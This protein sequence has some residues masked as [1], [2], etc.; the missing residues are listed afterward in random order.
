M[1]IIERQSIKGSLVNYL[2]VFIGFFATLF[3]Y[4]LDWELYGTIQYWI[5][6]AVILTPIL[7][8]GSTALLNKFYPHFKKKEIS[9][10]LGL[11]LIISTLTIM[12]M[13][14]L[15][16]LFIFIFRDFSFIQQMNIQSQSVVY[17]YL[18]AVVMIYFSIF[19]LHAANVRRIV[20][21]EIISKVGFKL[22]LIL[23]IVSSYFGILDNQWVG[24]LLVLFYLLACL[25]MYFYLII[26]GGLDLSGWKWKK[27]PRNLKKKMVSFWVF[28]GLNYLGVLLAYKIDLFMIG[29]LVDKVSVGYYSIFLF[30]VN[31]MIIPMTSINQIAGPIVSESFEN[32]DL[33]KIEQIYKKSSNTIFSFGTLVIIIIW[34]NIFFLLGIMR[35]GEDLIPYVSVILFLGLAKVFDLLTSIN[36][37]III[38]SRWYQLNLVFLAIMSVI[39]ILL[40]LYF[41][42]VYGII[43]A[44]YATSISLFVFNGIKSLFIYIKFGIH[45]FSK[46]TIYIV[47]MLAAGILIASTIQDYPIINDILSMIIYSSLTAI[48]YTY[49]NY[50]LGTSPELNQWVDKRIFRK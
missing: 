30:M 26:L 7:R 4:P 11:V 32:N 24:V 21:P 20:V 27:L 45:P 8:Q 14:L 28:G 34:M 39:N 37:L 2:G 18:L 35:N 49:L 29:T 47:L 46:H 9:G 1:G 17:I 3:I 10:L 40:N 42:D 19:Q 6:S 41:I 13:S 5:S 33:L 43:G 38:Y 22:F 36:N 48:I 31:L 25:T 50:K 15:L 23:L 44:S 12:A 16:F